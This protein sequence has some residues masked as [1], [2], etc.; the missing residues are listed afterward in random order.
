MEKRKRQR[1][2]IVGL[3][4]IL[5]IGVS[6]KG[7]SKIISE[8]TYEIPEAAEKVAMVLDGEWTPKKH[9]VEIR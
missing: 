6:A 1:L 7:N 9:L 4:L 2:L 3:V 5:F 8:S